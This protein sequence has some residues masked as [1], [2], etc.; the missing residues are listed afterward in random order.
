[1]GVSLGYGVVPAGTVV[2]SPCVAAYKPCGNTVPPQNNRS[3]R[4][5]IFTVAELGTKKKILQR[6]IGNRQPIQR[7]FKSVSDEIHLHKLRKLFTGGCVLK[8]VRKFCQFRR[9]SR[10]LQKLFIALVFF[11]QI[12][13]RSRKSSVLN[14]FLHRTVQSINKP[15]LPV[16]APHIH[17]K[18]NIQSEQVFITVWF[19][20][21]CL[22]SE[23]FRW[24]YP[25]FSL[26]TL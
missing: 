13:I 1:M 11:G 4:G 8:T 26:L 12:F 25:F 17:M 9:E 23:F 10:Q 14:T 6:S 24:T 18:G 2:I 21:N 16:A 3:S 20:I 19:K 15:L 7:I 5:V 22:L